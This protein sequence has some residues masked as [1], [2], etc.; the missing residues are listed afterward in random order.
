MAQYDEPGAL[1]EL[2]IAGAQRCKDRIAAMRCIR[3]TLPAGGMMEHRASKTA[4]APCF[5]DRLVHPPPPPPL[6]LISGV[7]A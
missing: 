1:G 2:Y 6:G 5:T 3:P 7:W 4:T